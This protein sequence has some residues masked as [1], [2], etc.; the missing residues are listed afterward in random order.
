MHGDRAVP[1]LPSGI[2]GQLCALLAEPIFSHH[3]AMLLQLIQLLSVAL[4]DICHAMAAEC[5]HIA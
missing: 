2:V 4:D 1:G 3:G 5:H